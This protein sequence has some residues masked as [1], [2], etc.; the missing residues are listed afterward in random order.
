[1]ILKLQLSTLS[2]HLLAQA[3]QQL[4]LSPEALVEELILQVLRAPNGATTAANLV[5]EKLRTLQETHDL[6][7]Q[8][9]RLHEELQNILP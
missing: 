8:T 9:A 3:C 4:H 2:S 1:M 5:N 6:L 7:K